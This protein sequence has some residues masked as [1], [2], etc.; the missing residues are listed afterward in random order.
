M[1]IAHPI[2]VLGSMLDGQ[3]GIPLPA[4]SL[5]GSTAN[6]DDLFFWLKVPCLGIFYAQVYPVAVQFPPYFYS[7]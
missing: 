4:S 7:L 1:A 5:S 2:L 6:F 3:S